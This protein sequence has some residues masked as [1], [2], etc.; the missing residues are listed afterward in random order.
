MSIFV[1]GAEEKLCRIVG[2]I[3]DNPT[4]WSVVSV[5][6][7]GSFPQGYQESPERA[8]ILTNI[9]QDRI[10]ADGLFHVFFCLDATIVIACKGIRKEMV[11]QAAHLVAN[12]LSEQNGGHFEAP[13][14]V[15]FMDLSIDLEPFQELCAR[16]LIW[17]EQLR[18]KEDLNREMLVNNLQKFIQKQMD[19]DKIR[20]QSH[21]L[22]IMFVED[23]PST[24]HLLARILDSE[25]NYE[26]LSAANARDAV[27]TYAANA[28]DLVFLDINLPVL[29]GFELLDT[30]LKMD[31]GAFVVMLSANSSQSNVIRAMDMGASGFIAKPFTQKKLKWYISKRKAIASLLRE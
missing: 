16:K 29:N 1:R 19:F 10:G 22:Q 14:R 3:N 24:R 27:E 26:T 23:D 7:P 31:R 30:F 17:A 28:P 12:A 20:K 11:M 8:R 5:P 18:E 13:N 4:G 21:R 25:P 9:I 2:K 6:V 15:S